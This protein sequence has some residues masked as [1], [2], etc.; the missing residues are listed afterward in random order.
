MARYVT[1]AMIDGWAWEKNVLVSPNGRIH[2]VCTRNSY[3]NRDGSRTTH[4]AADV[5]VASKSGI[6]E[7]WRRVP[8]EYGGRCGGSTNK[9]SRRDAAIDALDVT[10]SVRLR[11]SS[12]PSPED[13]AG[14]HPDFAK[15]L[16]ENRAAR[17]AIQADQAAQAAKERL[18]SLQQQLADLPKQ[19]EEVEAA[20][21]ALRL[22]ADRAKLLRALAYEDREEAERIVL[23]AI[24]EGLDAEW[25]SGIDTQSQA[26]WVGW[27]AGWRDGG[28]RSLNASQHALAAAQQVQAD[29]KEKLVRA[30]AL[31]V[32]F[33]VQVQP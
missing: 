27:A 17:E 30:A 10:F 8:Y 32:E 12:L 7:G 6:G 21:P 3:E 9:F 13:V 25:K 22:A 31:A 29:C 2:V 18:A 24:A 1:E 14:L 28:D 16:R 5:F 19:I 11:E 23:G 4:W 20:L 26:Y 33:A 15:R